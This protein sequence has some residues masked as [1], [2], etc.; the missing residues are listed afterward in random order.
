MNFSGF[1][2]W[3]P[4]FRGGRQIDSR[5]KEHDGDALIDKALANFNTAS[6]EPAACIGHP[7][8]DKP[9]YGWVSE[10]SKGADKLGTLLLAKFKQVEPTF[11]SMVKDG[12]FKKRSAAFYPNGTLR[13]VGFLGAMPPAVKG[14]PDVA[15]AEGEFATFDF[16]EPYQWNSLA[17][18]FRRIREYFIEKEGQETADRMIP[19][20]RIDDLRAA[21]QAPTDQPLTAS[22][23]EKEDN[24]MKFKEK[25][26]AFFKDLLD[27]MPDDGPATTVTDPP[28]GKFSEADLENARVEAARLERE[29]VT[30]EH[31]E[32]VI[33]SRQAAQR[34]EIST[35]CD[36]LVAQ[37]RILPATVKFGLP[38]ILFALASEENQIEFGESKEKATPYERMKA[39]LSAAK[40]LVTFGEVATRDR[41]TGGQAG[42][43][44]AKLE[45][46]VRAKMKENKDMSYSAA[47]A[48]AQQDNPELAQQYEE[49]FRGEG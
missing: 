29:K 47:F 1:D 32:K 15:F 42:T 14:L 18:I 12:R 22:Y 5:G 28:A 40:P 45:A 4:I 2:D 10:L 31:E 23:T 25:L 41:D 27:T 20:W 26:A 34:G 46:L 43:A 33:I 11:A 38:E 30:R 36:S 35:F 19:D 13:H 16:A 3:I 37:G 9:A 39:L 21:G 7:A 48:E 44:G 17:D 6:H 24:K 49:E 8:H